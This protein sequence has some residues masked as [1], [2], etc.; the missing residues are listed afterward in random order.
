[1]LHVL[2]YFQRSKAC[3]YDIVL[4]ALR[5]VLTRK[6]GYVTIRCL[7]G[8]EE[9]NCRGLSVFFCLRLKM[10]LSIYNLDFYGKLKTIYKS[11]LSCSLPFPLT[12]KTRL[13]VTVSRFDLVSS[14]PV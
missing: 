5:I 2:N 9:V 8:T 13:E 6:C 3:Y 10:N 4:T 7:I 1:M 12:A 14:M 11:D